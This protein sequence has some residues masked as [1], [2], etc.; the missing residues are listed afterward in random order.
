MENVALWHERD[1][2][3]SSIERVIFPDSTTIVDYMLTKMTSLMNNLL[4]YP[5]N[6][7]KNIHLTNGLIFSQ[8]ILLL[9]IKKG[10]T[11]EKAYEIVQNNAM[12]VWK[13]K[14]DFNTLLKSDKEIMKHVAEDEIDKLFDLSKILININKVYERLGL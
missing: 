7:K 6:M 1:I 10:L 4:I 2:S 9:L 5:E 13:E 11:R 14:I 12:K 8:E 3:H